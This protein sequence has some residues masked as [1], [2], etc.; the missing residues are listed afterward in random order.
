MKDHYI[1]EKMLQIEWHLRNKSKVLPK[2]Q[3]N[4]RCAK[5]QLGLRRLG[6]ALRLDLE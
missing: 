5:R 2:E 6:T 3:R 1:L 4:S